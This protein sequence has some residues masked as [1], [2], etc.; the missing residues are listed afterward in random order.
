M[1]GPVGLG[2]VFDRPEFGVLVLPFFF[3][4][5]AVHGPKLVLLFLFFSNFSS[6]DSPSVAGQFCSQTERNSCD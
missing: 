4:D 2:G 6:K 5:W 3:G 1:S